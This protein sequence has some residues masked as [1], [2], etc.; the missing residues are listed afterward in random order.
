MT[1]AL[2]R[3]SLLACA[4]AAGVSATLPSALQAGV[5]KGFFARKKL[6]IGI[7]LY[8]LGDEGA[9]DFEGTMKRLAE[10]GYREIE[11]PG[12]MG[13][14]PADIRRVADANGLKVSS[15]H[16]GPFPSFSLKNDPK[17]LAEVAG[18]I[19]AKRIVLPM[20]SGIWNGQLQPGETPQ[21]AIMRGVR[22]NGVDFWKQLAQMLN[23]RAAALKPHGIELSYH[24]HS[25]EFLP[26]EGA[27]TGW[28][29]L[30]KE[31]DP[32][33]VFFEADV[34]WL[35]S[36]G[37]DPIAFFKRHSGRI[38]QLH[39]KDVQRGFKPA[40]DLTTAPTEVGSGSV[41]WARVLPAAYA[42]GARHFYVEQEAPFTMPRI[43]A[44]AKSYA[45]LAKLKA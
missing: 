28:D 40:T 36:A 15:I 11:L 39:V 1:I 45:Y 34:G 25:F 17:Q 16:A 8:T 10:I 38:R 13:R 43:D 23:E 19:G 6:P 44:A 18:V 4:A 9:K 24:N 20:P 42:A 29:V 22:A 7:Q 3:R 30:A 12:L 26:L 41:D 35:T 32:K 2:S 37:I 14:K 5:S 31:T 27:T 21:A 33:L